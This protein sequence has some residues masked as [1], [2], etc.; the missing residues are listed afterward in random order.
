MIEIASAASSFYSN[1]SS[2][3]ADSLTKVFL[4]NISLWTREYVMFF[5]SRLVTQFYDVSY[6]LRFC[7]GLMLYLFS[8]KHISL[9]ICQ[10]FLQNLAKRSFEAYQEKQL[11]CAGI[12]CCF[13]CWGNLIIKGQN[14]NPCLLGK[15]ALKQML[16]CCCFFR[17]FSGLYYRNGRS[18]TKNFSFCLANLQ[19]NSSLTK[20]SKHFQPFFRSSQL[21]G[22][23]QGDV[24]G[25]HK[26]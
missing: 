24:T 23:C 10:V 25:I 1:L 20:T 16:F 26:R 11:I 2:E 15:T 6:F 4:K 8:I 18:K 7:I 14:A 12:N 13:D 3:K 17:V 19:A 21:C 22:Y 5:F 9:V